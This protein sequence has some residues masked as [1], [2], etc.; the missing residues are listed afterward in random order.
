MYNFISKI[1]NRK[2]ENTSLDSTLN[3]YNNQYYFNSTLN[4]LSKKSMVG[5][6]RRDK[7]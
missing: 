7:K 4:E 3:H 6:C 5:G 1:L 2:T